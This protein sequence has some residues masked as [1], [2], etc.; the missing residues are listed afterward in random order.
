MFLALQTTIANGIK[1][2]VA[3]SKKTVVNF[4]GTNTNPYLE[5]GPRINY[6]PS[7]PRC[8]AAWK[9]CVMVKDCYSEALQRVANKMEVTGG[10][11]KVQEL[12]KWAPSATKLQRPTNSM[13]DLDRSSMSDEAKE[14]ERAILGQ[15]A[16]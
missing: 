4:A 13:E 8:P 14:E 10:T 12:A 11:F 3:P 9:F 7:T 16:V 6:R 1:G 5:I 15:F 2:L